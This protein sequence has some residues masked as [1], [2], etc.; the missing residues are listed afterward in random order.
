[1][2]IRT[3]KPGHSLWAELPKLAKFD[4]QTNTL[5][6]DYTGSR[7]PV[8]KIVANLVACILKIDRPGFVALIPVYIQAVAACSKIG[9][10]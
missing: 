5:I 9:I 2:T 4:S 3:Q 6:V 10:K 7:I 1:M 8:V